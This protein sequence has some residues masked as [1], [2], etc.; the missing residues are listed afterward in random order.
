MTD[1]PL[2]DILE[3]LISSLSCDIV[4]QVFSAAPEYRAIPEDWSRFSWRSNGR[5]SVGTFS[6][7]RGFRL[8]PKLSRCRPLDCWSTFEGREQH[9]Q[10]SLER[11][12]M[13]L[14]QSS[15]STLLQTG[16]FPPRPTKPKPKPPLPVL[17]GPLGCRD[18]ASWLGVLS[19]RSGMRRPMLFG[20]NT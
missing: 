3:C 20:S 16:A 17:S 8:L 15:C 6:R 5:D 10:Q 12:C 11:R 13:S 19:L 14:S 1:R 4:S 9:V 18:G 2:V 7:H